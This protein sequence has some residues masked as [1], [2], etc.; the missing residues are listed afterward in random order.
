MRTALYIRVSSD[1][2][3]REGFSIEAQ[4]AYLERE[5]AKTG[6]TI[7][8]SYIDDGYSA[9]DM[10]RPALQR[11]LK[12]VESRGFEVIFFWRLDRLTRKSRDFHKLSD[13]L[14][15]YR[16]G[17]KSATDPI[18]TTTAIGRFQLELSV[19]LAQLERETISERVFFVME[20]RARK[21]LR[22]GAPAPIGYDDIDQ[23]LIVNPD[24]AKVVKEIFDLYLSGT[25][26]KSLAK[27]LVRKNLGDLKWSGAAV[28]YLLQNPVYIGKMR[29]NYID[30][31][32]KKKTGKDI[33]T[34]GDHEP[35]IDELTFQRTQTEIKRRG[36]GGKKNTSQFLF[37]GVVKCG[38]CG[39]SMH[40]QSYKKGDVHLY[41][42]YRCIAKVDYGTCDMPYIREN[43]ISE[44][45]LDALDMDSTE[46]EK[47]IQIQDHDP[48]KDQIAEMKKELVT[49]AR[50]KQKWQ[51][52]YANELCSLEEL[53]QNTEPDILQEKI[54]RK[55]LEQIAPGSKSHW[56]KEELVHQLKE[57]RV[58]W[59][60][61]DN[62]KAKK[63]FIQEAFEYIKVDTAPGSKTGQGR[64][65][66][67]VITDFRF[68]I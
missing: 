25:G 1:E 31:R 5:A 65:P 11:M 24:Q 46:L 64:K 14:Q 27:I 52:M 7:V 43:G 63:L 62:D 20:E 21:G 26:M 16:C 49:I 66:K 61:I 35:I 41:R 37:S 3:A 34:D 58:A 8:D 32:T 29:W 54:I 6:L 28:R 19:S 59:K 30:Q 56:S 23:K 60:H 51:T 48:A 38:R 15:K 45:F 44:A 33:I 12:D 2:Q 53:K 13:Q 42:T 50:R 36:K 47:Y 68:R 57:I 55:Q 4:K 18:D 9:K 39:S 22:N 40:G 10:K 67:I 17:F